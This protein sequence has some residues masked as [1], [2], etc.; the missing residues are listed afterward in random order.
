MGL[1]LVEGRLVE[2]LTENLTDAKCHYSPLATLLG[3]P[4]ICGILES[5]NIEIFEFLEKA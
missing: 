3:I 5:P 4:R 1:F 2:S